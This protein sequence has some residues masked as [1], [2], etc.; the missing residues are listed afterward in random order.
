VVVVEHRDRLARFGV[1]DLEAALAAHGRRVVVAEPGERTGD[2]VREMIGILPS[3]CAGLYGRR[4]ARSRA[5]R[6]VTA[7]QHTAT[8]HTAEAGVL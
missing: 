1:E 5:L 4:G 8:R 6:A 7:T 3:M 2:L